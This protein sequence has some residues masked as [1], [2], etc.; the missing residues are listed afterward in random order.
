MYLH[1]VTS[2]AAVPYAAKRN[3]AAN[4]VAADRRRLMMARDG[5][6]MSSCTQKQCFRMQRIKINC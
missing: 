6:G 1:P 3:A 4:R 2:N 5:E